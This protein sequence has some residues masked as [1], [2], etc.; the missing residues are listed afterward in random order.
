MSDTILWHVDTT[1]SLG[2]DG[3]PD[4]SVDIT[5]AGIQDERA[6][7]AA[8]PTLLRKAAE[9]LDALAKERA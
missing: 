1:I 3:K 5:P 8:T 6:I 9:D 4:I 2:D 7:L